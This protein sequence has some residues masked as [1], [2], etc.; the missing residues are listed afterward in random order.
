MYK[1]GDR[2]IYNSKYKKEKMS[3]TII[4]ICKSRSILYLDGEIEPL[5][6][7]CLND[8]C[9]LFVY[10]LSCITMHTPFEKLSNETKHKISKKYHNDLHEIE[11]C[12]SF[13]KENPIIELQ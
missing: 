5:S 7:C 8:S 4:D 2:V 3:A 11:F 9:I 12:L 10:D 1:I 13:Y 6:K